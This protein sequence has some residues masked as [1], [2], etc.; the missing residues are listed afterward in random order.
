V[1]GLAVVLA[2]ASTANAQGLQWMHL[3][4]P[5]V[6]WAATSAN[7]FWTTNNG[8]HWNDITPPRPI[9]D[10]GIASVF[11]L[12][13]SIGWV[14]L[15]HYDEP[16]PR[17]DLAYTKD[18]GATWSLT[19]LKIPVSPGDLILLPEGSMQF[20]DASHGWMNL[21]VGSSSNFH[22]GLLLR[23]EN[24]G[25]TWIYSNGPGTNGYVQFIDHRNGWI[26]SPADGRLW[27]T[28][29]GAATW[30]Q[31]LVTAP[32]QLPHAE[33]A[34]YQLP[35]FSDQKHGALLV[36]FPAP[37]KAPGTQLPVL[38]ITNDQGR[39]WKFDTVLSLSAGP[40]GLP[41][42]ISDAKLLAAQTAGDMLRLNRIPLNTRE[43]PTATSANIGFP[44][45]VLSLSFVNEQHGWILASTSNC[46]VGLLPCTQVLSTAD[47]GVTWADITPG[48]KEK[49]AAVP[50]GNPTHLKW[51]AAGILRP[52][53]ADEVSIHLG[54]DMCKTPGGNTN[55]PSQ[56]Q[57]LWSYSSF[58][59]VGIYIQNSP[60]ASCPTYEPSA[61][62]IEGAEAQGWGIMPIWSGLQAPCACRPAVAA[63]TPFPH[64]FSS[65]PT[66]AMLDGEGQARLAVMN[67]QSLGIDGRN[68]LR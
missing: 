59:N 1:A 33:S 38:F 57:N 25:K 14:L 9:P 58:Q 22:L 53:S 8:Q 19:E 50:L 66:Q 17:F 31:V 46:S 61:N 4:G 35:V 26:A 48:A 43:N 23:T 45:A 44:G 11:F 68:Y 64:V 32:V 20:T 12:D 42:A 54:F 5:G 6:G 51:K 13:S 55:D 10:E 39:G 67:A 18:S 47:A 24:G 65:N 37:P 56:M 3:L 52:S 62:W 29:D 30:S 41:D 40:S 7:L 60:S 16:M 15:A 2:V 36:D 49:K 21:A 28:H 27:A 63:C 34:N